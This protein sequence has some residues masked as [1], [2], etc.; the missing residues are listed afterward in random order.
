MNFF[1]QVLADQ[2]LLSSQPFDLLFAMSTDFLD[3]ESEESRRL[4][5]QAVL[6]SNILI[7]DDA[8]EP[9]VV[10]EALTNL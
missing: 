4:F 2:S 6:N 3:P 5:A 8:F 9:Q 1:S 10:Y 7:I